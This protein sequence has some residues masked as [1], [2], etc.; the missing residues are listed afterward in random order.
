[1]QN[2]HAFCHLAVPLGAIK[3][4]PATSCLEIKASEGTSAVSGNYW[5]DSVKPG[6]VTLVFC[7]MRPE[8]EFSWA[9]RKL[10]NCFQVD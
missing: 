6:Q 9:I 7:D 1:M 10:F 8:G 2:P 5:L 3:E 4:V